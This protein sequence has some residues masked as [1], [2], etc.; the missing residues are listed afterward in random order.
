MK[1]I[2]KIEEWLNTHREI[3]NSILDDI[4]R[5][6]EAEEEISFEDWQDHDYYENRINGFIECLLIL[7]PEYYTSEFNGQVQGKEEGGV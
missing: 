3:Y 6:E 1:K 5:K 4:N 2:P 7:E